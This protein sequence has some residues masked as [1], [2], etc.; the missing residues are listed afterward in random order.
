VDAMDIGEGGGNDLDLRPG[1]IWLIESHTA[2]LSALERRALARADVVL[3]ERPLAPILAEVLPPGSYAEPL[4]TIAED[5]AGAIPA[6][7][8][9]LAA[10]GW[11]VVHLGQPC[12]ERRRRLRGDGDTLAPP[13]G[14]GCLVMRLVAKGAGNP[15]VGDAAAGLLELAEIENKPAEN[16]ALTIIV[17]PLAA[18]AASSAFTAN[19]LAG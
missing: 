10:E 17:G 6:R 16:E 9:K 4:A 1:E 14:N 18:A 13:S 11:R 3:Y 19:G 2:G 8:L 5:D 15:P 7:A 12:P